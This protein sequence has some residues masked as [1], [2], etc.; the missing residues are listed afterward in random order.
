MKLEDLRGLV[1]LDV[2]LTGADLERLNLDVAAKGHVWMRAD[3]RDQAL[4]LDPFRV[5]IQG[6]I[7]GGKGSFSLENLPLTLLALATPV[8]N[9]LRGGESGGLLSAGIRHP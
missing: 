9:S 7:Q 3:D 2:N 4:E 5:R 6:P 8:P 1:D